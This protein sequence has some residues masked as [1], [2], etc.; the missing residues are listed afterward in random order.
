VRGG[1]TSSE[2]ES[3]YL[4]A[5]YSGGETETGRFTAY[6]NPY[7]V[8][9]PEGRYTKHIY[10]GSQR[11]VSKLG[12]LE[13]FGQDPRRVAYAGQNVDG[14]NGNVD[15]AKKYRDAQ[16]TIKNRY[17]EV[18]DMPFNGKMNDDPVNGNNFC[19]RDNSALRAGNIGNG[20]E[21][22]EKLHYYYHSDHLG[23][24]SLITNLDGE[25]VQ[26]VEY[27]PWGEVFIE[28]RNNTWNTPF[29]FNAKELDE[30]TGLYYYHARYYDPRT[31]I[32]YGVDPPLI[33]GTYLS[34]K[35]NGG[36]FNSFNLNPYIY[37]S[38]NPMNRIDPD[39]LN[40]FGLD[41]NSGILS[42]IDLTKDESD[43]IIT[44]KFDETGKF[45]PNDK[46]N[47]I[48][49]VSKGVLNAENKQQDLSTTGFVTTGGNQEDGIDAMYFISTQTGIELDGKGF[50]TND[51]VPELLVGGWSENSTTHAK[52][53]K[54]NQ[55]GTVTF[56]IHTHIIGK[57]GNPKL[58][59]GFAGEKDL[60]RVARYPAYYILS[61]RN[62]L[63]QYYPEKGRKDCL[64]HT[65][66]PLK[67]TVPSSLQKH[68]RVTP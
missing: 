68:I 62:G 43:F 29:L 34:G 58:G 15:Y 10:I 64:K 46:S 25:V 57:E 51:G 35:M 8:V 59:Y 39:G 54:F 33:D 61:E 17:E 65:K 1:K 20:N 23:S 36:V 48:L 60:D 27:T 4:N 28:E 7:L 40:D 41:E 32:F 67:S 16:D 66:Y 50:N 12:D 21:N 37:C 49:K 47:S 22:P 30:E 44:G 19:C 13:S 2:N 9:S 3:I 26:H 18:F 56:D 55:Q 38:N 5:L 42:L 53:T 63:T 45:T 11:I 31:S 14:A 52:N 6:I 24:T